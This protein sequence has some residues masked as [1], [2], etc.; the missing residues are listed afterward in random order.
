MP[1]TSIAR[2]VFRLDVL[3]G[4]DAGVVYEDVEPPATSDDLFHAVSPRVLIGNVEVA[5]EGSVPVARE[6]LRQRRPFEIEHIGDD[7]LRT[8]LR[9]LSA[10]RRA[11]AARRARDERD[12]ARQVGLHR[13]PF[14]LDSAASASALVWCTV[15]TGW[16][17]GA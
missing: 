1:I 4:A 3:H 11:N 13:A 17:G 7:N 8:K 14:A 15:P 12:S 2:P 6:L 10:R 5:V 16:W 9:Q